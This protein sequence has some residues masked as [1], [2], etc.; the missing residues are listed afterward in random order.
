MNPVEHKFCLW[1]QLE[2]ANI[3]HERMEQ[4]KR[5]AREV[6]HEVWKQMY[7]W[8]GWTCMEIGKMYG[9]SES[10]V[11]RVIA[12][13]EPLEPEEANDCDCGGEAY[14]KLVGDEYFR[15]CQDCGKLLEDK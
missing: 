8:D 1:S 11:Y 7:Y 9:F 12:T 6:M 4:L 10:T 3:D 15:I 5:D 14:L 13:G 2:D